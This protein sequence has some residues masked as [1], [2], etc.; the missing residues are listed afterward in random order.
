MSS[1]IY[2]KRDEFDIVNFLFLD[3]DIARATSCG[4]YISQLIRIARVSSQV[5][6][7]NTR[8]TILTMKFLKESYRYHKL[9]KAFSQFYRRYCDLVSKFNV[10]LKSLLKRGLSKIELYGD[11]NRVHM[12]NLHTGVV[13][14]LGAN[15][16]PG[17]NLLSLKLLLYVKKIC[18]T[19][20]T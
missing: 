17:M 9:R 15:L 4:D 10:G 18:R 8:N 12:H 13:F 2:D 14:L 7:L 11:F 19:I 16:H 20:K 6:D 1:K 5:A 3:G